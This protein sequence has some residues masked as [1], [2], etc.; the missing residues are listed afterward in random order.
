MIH[1]VQNVT[2]WWFV[3]VDCLLSHTCMIL[4]TYINTLRQFLDLFTNTEFPKLLILNFGNK[5]E[6]LAI[7]L[8]AVLTLANHAH[9]QIAG[10]WVYWLNTQARTQ[11]TKVQFLGEVSYN[12]SLAS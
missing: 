12:V 6:F 5:L 2:S 3:N 7:E 8:S 4:P 10:H 11:F 1:N 9:A